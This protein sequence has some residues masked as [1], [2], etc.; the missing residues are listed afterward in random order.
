MPELRTLVPDDAAAMR[1]LGDLAFAQTTT[2]ERWDRVWSTIDLD[3]HVG[4][5]DAGQLVGQA[6]AITMS[7]TVPGPCVARVAGVTGVLVS[8][9]H[10][11]RGVL[12]SLMR[13]QLDELHESGEAIAILWASEPGI[14]GRFGYGVASRL[15]NVIV[16]HHG[17]ALRPDTPTPSPRVEVTELD[18]AALARCRAVYDKSG[19][20]RPGTVSRTRSH[21]RE[22][23]YDGPDERAGASAM[24]CLFVGDDSEDRGYAWFRTSGKWSVGRPTGRVNV[25]ETVGID[26]SAEVA[27]LRFLLS[28]DLMTETSWWNL[29][30]D[31]SLIRLL[32]DPRIARPTTLDQL[33]LRPVRVPEAL[34]SRGYR[35]PVDVV[36]GVRDSFCPW[37]EGRW[38]LAGDPSGATSHRT[39]DPADIELD[40]RELGATILGD[41]SLG[42][43]ARAGLVKEHTAGAVSRLAAAAASDLAPWCSFVF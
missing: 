17:S 32:V 35:L 37:N 42:A 8:P 23:S 13:H 25:V 3:R 27:L 21:W 31:H 36:L 4:S 26:A 39:T 15:L 7:M 1:R 9:T 41:D 12:T 30:L 18:G 43:A 34:A 10:R 5:F 29:P 2:D 6:G 14:Y 38:R 20:Y 16:A 28:I 19:R 33:W 24:R 40:V 11:R 22:S